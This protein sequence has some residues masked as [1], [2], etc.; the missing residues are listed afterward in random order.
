LKAPLWSSVSSWP[1]RV[2]LMVGR[3]E[4]SWRWW[5]FHGNCFVLVPALAVGTSSVDYL[6]GRGGAALHDPE[7][8]GR[9]PS[10][11]AVSPA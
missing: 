2:W 1:S 10:P 4:V 11:M 6:I 3:K 9:V 7:R 8:E 5:R